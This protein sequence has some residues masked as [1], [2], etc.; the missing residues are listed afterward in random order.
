MH[1]ADMN[2]LDSKMKSC[3]IQTYHKTTSL[4]PVFKLN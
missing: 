2:D 3:G 1:S 4:L